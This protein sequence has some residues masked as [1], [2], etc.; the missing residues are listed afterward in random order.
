M[1]LEIMGATP[2]KTWP[3]KEGEIQKSLLDSHKIQS[4]WGWKPELI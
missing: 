1:L 4:L 3:K 2:K